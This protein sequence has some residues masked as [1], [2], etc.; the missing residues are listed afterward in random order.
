MKWY[1]SLPLLPLKILLVW[2]PGPWLEITGQSELSPVQSVYATLVWFRRSGEER[3][4][5][6]VWE[7]VWEVLPPHSGGLTALVEHLGQGP[8]YSSCSMNTN[9][10]FL[11]N[12]NYHTFQGVPSGFSGPGTLIAFW[13]YPRIP[14]IASASRR[15]QQPPGFSLHR[16]REVTSLKPDWPAAGQES[17][18]LPWPMAESKAGSAPYP[19][20]WP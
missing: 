5:L 14:T 7:M 18:L 6:C 12:G 15:P 1:F 3:K 8:E 9:F 20:V 4:G 11:F 2:C 16:K 13:D 19:A 17:H 10:F